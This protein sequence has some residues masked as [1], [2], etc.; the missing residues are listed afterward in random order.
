MN[1]ALKPLALLITLVLCISGC[2]S[3]PSKPFAP[4][5][6][7]APAVL[8]SLRIALASASAMIGQNDQ[9]TV[10]G[11]DQKGNPIQIAVTLAYSSSNTTV[12][13]VSSAGL[14][15]ALAAGSSTITVSAAGLPPTTVTVTVVPESPA[16]KTITISPI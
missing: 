4:S 11:L 2:A 8:T 7:P 9:I 15:Q 12:A 3:A 6:Q 14:I 1:P 5:D 16:L 10:T 13:T